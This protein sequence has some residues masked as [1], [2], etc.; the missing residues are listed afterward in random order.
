LI[1][2]PV[3]EILLSIFQCLK[4]AQFP[5]YLA[6]LLNVTAKAIRLFC[7]KLRVEKYRKWHDQYAFNKTCHGNFWMGHAGVLSE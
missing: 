4:V 1:L 2:T 5:L 7:F 3:H 6:I